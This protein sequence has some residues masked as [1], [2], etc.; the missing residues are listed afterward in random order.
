MSTLSFR[1]LQ[2]AVSA[3]ALSVLASG[4]FA[5]S[6]INGSFEVVV[7]D[8]GPSGDVGVGTPFAASWEVDAGNINYIGTFWP[9]SDGI[10]SVDL[11]GAAPGAIRQTFDTTPGQ[12]YEV[13][14][15]MAG[16]PYGG[17]NTLIKTLEVSLFGATTMY[18]SPSDY[19]ALAQFT[20]DVSGQ[21]GTNLGWAGK[22]LQFLADDS[23]TVLRFQSLTTSN[24]VSGLPW[25]GPTL[26]NVRVNAVPAPATL[27]LLATAFGAAIA[28]RR[29]GTKSAPDE[30][31]DQS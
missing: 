3:A 26:D 2:L 12:L 18:G 8:P 17:D 14:F 11:N 4:G 22:L 29:N 25:Y 10:Y 9:A 28:W 16:N 27:P 31:S 20:F 24:G 19:P 6:F 5:A 1:F 15:D 13:L 30:N 7:N 21:S 23:S